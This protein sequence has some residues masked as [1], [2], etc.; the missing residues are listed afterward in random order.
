M[1]NERGEGGEV[2]TDNGDDGGSGGGGGGDG[3]GVDFVRVKMRERIER[4]EG[5]HSTCRSSRSP[6]TTFRVIRQPLRLRPF[7]FDNGDNVRR[8]IN[9][10][11]K[12]SVR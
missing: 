3:D 4:R 6:A 5:E 12:L 10:T 2:F 8:F 9:D 7:R 1:R 11:R